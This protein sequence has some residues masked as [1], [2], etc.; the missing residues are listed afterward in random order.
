[1]SFTKSRIKLIFTFVIALLATVVLVACGGNEPEIEKFRVEFV[2]NGGTPQAA[3]QLVDK[4]GKVTRPTEDPVRDGYE[5]SGWYKEASLDNLWRFNI[6]TVNEDIKIYAGWD[7]A[8]DPVVT[9]VVTFEGNGADDIEPASRT[10][11]EG[12]TVAAPLVMREGYVLVGWFSDEELTT[13][14]DFASDVVNDN[15]TLYAKWAVDTTADSTPIR[16]QDELYELITGVTEYNEGDKFHLNS[17]L[18]FANFD[19]APGGYETSPETIHNF[20]L[21]GNGYTISNLTIASPVRGGL[22]PLMNGGS[23]KNLNLNNVVVT[24]PYQAGILIGRVLNG[25]VVDV[26][27]VVITNSSVQSG[28]VGAG[29]LIGHVQGAAAATTVNISG[30]AMINVDVTSNSNAAGGV[31]GDVESSVVNIADL[32]L[33]VKVVTTGERVGAVIGELRRNS[34]ST[35]LP[36]FT[37]ERAIVKADLQG[38]RYLGTI[39]RSD[40]NISNNDDYKDFLLGEMKDIIVIIN[41]E[42]TNLNDRNSGVLGRSQLNVPTNFWSVGYNVNLLNPAGLFPAEQYMLDL[43]SELPTEALSPFASWGPSIDTL[44]SLLGQSLPELHL[45]ELTVAD[46]VIN[47]YVT[48]GREVLGVAYSS[49]LGVFKNWLL[50]SEPFSGPVNADLELVAEFTAIYRV[51]FESN[52]GSTVNAVDVFEGELLGE[53]TEP[54]RAGFEFL[55]WFVDAEL[56]E[57]YSFGEPVTSDFTL[58]A[59]WEN[60]GL[61]S[62]IV[63]FETDGGSPIQP[64]EVVHGSVLALPASPSKAGFAFTGWYTNVEAT[65]PFDV[66]SIIEESMTLYAGWEATT[67]VGTAI[68]NVTEFM[69]FLGSTSGDYYLANDIDLTGQVF[70]TT[71]DGHVFTGTFNGNNKTISGLSINGEVRTGLFPNINGATIENL[72]IENFNVVSTGRGGI[73]VG[74]VQ[75]S[76]STISNITVRNSSITGKNSNGVGGLIGQVSNKLTISLITL[77]GLTVTNTENNVGGF[78]GRIDNANG[79]LAA[80]EILVNNVYVVGKD[81]N[82]DR[83]ASLV[84]GYVANNAGAKGILNNVVVINSDINEGTTRGVLIGYNREPGYME[85]NNVYVN[86]T[87]TVGA[88][89]SGLQGHTHAS[90]NP[91]FLNVDTVYGVLENANDQTGTVQML[92]GNVMPEGANLETWLQTVLPTIANNSF[93]AAIFEEPAVMHRVT[94]ESNGGSAVP[95]M[96]VEPGSLLED[97]ATPTKSGYEFLGWFKDLELTEEWQATDVVEDDITLYAKWED[98]VDPQIIVSPEVGQLTVLPEESFVLRVEV[99]DENPYRLEVDHSFEGTLPEFTVYA[100]AA[101]PYG[102]VEAQQAFEAIGVSVVYNA[103]TKTFV[104][105]FGVQVTH[106]HFVDNGVTFYLV[107]HDIDGNASGSMY[108]VTP[109]MTFAYT[110]VVPSNTFTV[111][112]DSQGGNVIQ[113]IEVAEGATLE[114]LP[115][116]SREGFLFLGWFKDTL[117]AEAWLVDDVVVEDITLYAKWEESDLVGTAITTIEQFLELFAE[118]QTGEFYLANDLDFT[119]F[120]LPH[121]GSGPSFKGILDGNNKT[122]I[123]LRVTGGYGGLFP[124]ANGAIIKNLIIDGF[125]VIATGRGGILIGRVEN[126]SVAITNVTIRNSSITG[127]GSEGVSG[128][129]GQVSN[130]LSANQIKLENLEITSTANNVGG[131]V[132]R[133]DNAKGNLVASEILIDNIYIIGKSGS[134]DRG[135]GLVIGYV[136]NTDGSRG[137]VSN[138]VVINSDIKEDTTRGVLISYHRS[139]GVVEF[140]NI[141]VDITFSVGTIKSG[142]QAHGDGVLNVSTVYGRLVN[143]VTGTGTVHLLPENVMAQNESLSNWLPTVLPTIYN[144]PFFAHLFEE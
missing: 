45:V 49:E 2:M 75:D 84:V 61:S 80:S 90:D 111:T 142:L 15:I 26:E 86:V 144:N 120:T 17:D 57:E 21:D 132:G 20:N 63:T 103:A 73:L 66:N 19:W 126:N 28:A 81:G 110:F 96:Q 8:V 36:D 100:D 128:F 41:S 138:A 27:N 33:E 13:E 107:A 131:L 135:A 89:K 69:N 37:L 123:G 88:V 35:D 76:E 18:N 130:E 52:G 7:E 24:S 50:D 125:E 116:L 85:F 62:H 16:S 12:S 83:G 39:G 70:S 53:P 141:F 47:Q 6:D 94:F 82:G 112:F 68:S 77:E 9:Y 74:R 25:S 44:P 104:I 43:L 64:I 97:L 56:T 79:H 1:M 38:L 127:G 87:L 137:V 29:G 134:G 31:V 5:F 92:P 40:S 115:V 102:S 42:Q 59:G 114:D 54:T 122:L 101:N 124:R 113:S 78:V 140:N 98:V 71:G 10:V 67:L 3:E 99:I 65:D 51:L 4:G 143:D 118:E 30:L 91:I 14:W 139:P 109:E 136:A 129:V 32:L 72:V 46:N 22:I 58:Y 119:G 48:T 133:I 23:V 108:E 105:D 121:D 60:L 55:G 11:N 34:G 95:F 117:G 93:F 106:T